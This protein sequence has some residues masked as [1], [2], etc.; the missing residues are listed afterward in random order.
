VLRLPKPPLRRKENLYVAW[1]NLITEWGWDTG[2][3]KG[4]RPVGYGSSA[5]FL[6]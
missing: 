4:L 6:G 2:P 1:P 3:A 5:T